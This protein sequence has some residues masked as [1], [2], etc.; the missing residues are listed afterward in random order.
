MLNRLSAQPSS[1]AA[2]SGP[3]ALGIGLRHPHYGA[4]L[5]Q[6]PAIDFLEA[7]S[8]NFFGAGGA[9]LAVL[10]QA[11][12]HYPISLHGVGLS[13]GSAAGLDPWHLEQLAQLVERIEPARVSDHASFSRG[14]WRG[15][16]VHASDL[17]PLPFSAEALR[18][19]SSHIDQV[20]TR[21]ARRFLVENISA[22]LNWPV[23]HHE[24]P[25]AEAEFLAE[26][27]RRTGC[28]L[29]VDV[30]N[31]YV[32]AL[33]AAQA[34]ACADPEA[35]CRAW[36]D[37]IPPEAVGQVHLAGHC[38]VHDLQGD[39]VID[40]HGSR[41]CEAVWRL[42]RHAMARF[43]AVPTLIEWDTDIPALEVLLDEAEKA[44]AVCEGVFSG[45]LADVSTRTGPGVKP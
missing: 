44:R 42:Y 40:D 18:V 14:F 19:L 5:E 25:M 8:E 37:A 4:L 36:L 13:L 1:P 7:H 2:P 3:I 22:Y 27:A 20:Q 16:M 29:L 31:V 34:G 21:L 43:G 10:E 11:R 35:S 41:V 39:I 9:A 15:G 45:G 24:G 26:L 38:H 32:N 30:N 33:N 12:A 17:L 23:Q 28:L 6:L